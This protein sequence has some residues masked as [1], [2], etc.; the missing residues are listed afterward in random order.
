MKNPLYI[1][2]NEKN[3]LDIPI[4]DEQHRAFI[5]L[6]NTFHYMLQ[7]GKGF[8]IINKNRAIIL[9]HFAEIHFKVEE[10]IMA[11]AGYPLLEKHIEKHKKIMRGIH[12]TVQEVLTTGDPLTA[13][14]FVRDW[15][16]THINKQDRHFCDYINKKGINI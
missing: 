3:N 9:Q 5:A 8:N 7:Q 11:K 16:L 6:L 2:W 13:L 15:W 14:E 4:I 10:D 12:K 1:E